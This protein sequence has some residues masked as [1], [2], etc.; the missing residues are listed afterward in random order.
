MAPTIYAILITISL[1]WAFFHF[2][3]EGAGQVFALVGWIIMGT[4]ALGAVFR[5]LR[6]VL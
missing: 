1:I 2:G 4:F 5:L 6:A 3:G